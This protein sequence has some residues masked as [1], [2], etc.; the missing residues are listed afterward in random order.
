MSF[1]AATFRPRRSN[2]ER[3]S[4]I[5]PRC[6]AS[7]FRR[8]K[9]RS[10]TFTSPSW[11]SSRWERAPPLPRPAPA[12]GLSLRGPHPAFH[13]ERSRGGDLLGDRNGLFGGDPASGPPERLRPR[14][15][16]RHAPELQHIRLAFVGAEEEDGPILADEHLA[17]AGLDLVAAE[18]ARASGRHRL[19]GPRACGPRARSRGA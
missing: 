1:N 17:G 7:G 19:T 18:G 4:P 6:T 2:R 3:I 12:Y 9:V 8:T 5:R 13:R 10:A 16:P 11:P 15:P 14:R